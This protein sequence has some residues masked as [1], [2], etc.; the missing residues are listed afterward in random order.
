MESSIFFF[1]CLT[2]LEALRNRALRQINAASLNVPMLGGVDN[3][4]RA[5]GGEHQ[6]GPQF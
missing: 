3:A 1:F 2:R 4:A 6:H 5:F